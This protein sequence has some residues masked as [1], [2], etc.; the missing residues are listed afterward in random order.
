MHEK[1]TDNFNSS[2]FTLLKL[3]TLKMSNKSQ[4]KSTRNKWNEDAVTRTV[5]R[6]PVN[7]VEQ[8]PEQVTG[9]S[10]MQIVLD[11]ITEPGNYSKYKGGSSNGKSKIY[12]HGLIVEIMKK[13]GIFHRQVQ[14]VCTQISILE[15]QFKMAVD[16]KNSTGQGVDEDDK[17]MSAE[18]IRGIY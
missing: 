13:E 4:T 3:N 2:F 5:I 6:P 11:W 1:L 10:S 14:N 12:Y 7:G 16:W 18:S 9:R 17:K 8:E 15:K